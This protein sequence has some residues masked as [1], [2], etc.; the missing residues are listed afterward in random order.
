MFQEICMAADHVSDNYLPVHLARTVF[1]PKDWVQ[2]H[3]LTLSTPV[4]CHK[5]FCLHMKG[6]LPQLLAAPVCLR[7]TIVI[8]LY[9]YY[10]YILLFYCFFSKVQ[11]SNKLTSWW[12]V[13][14]QVLHIQNIQLIFGVHL[15]GFH[16]EKSD[17]IIWR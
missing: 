4:N 12:L 5:Q 9:Y 13:L 15:G 16:L 3:Y 7:R 14:L 17:N 10:Y 8:I 11:N 1:P 2:R 6:P